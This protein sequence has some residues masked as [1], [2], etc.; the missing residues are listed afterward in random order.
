MFFLQDLLSR[1]FSRE[2]SA[3]IHS[4][5]HGAESVPHCSDRAC[6]AESPSGSPEGKRMA[7]EGGIAYSGD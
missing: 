7:D 2:D 5:Q 4:E 3:A 1:W 6:P